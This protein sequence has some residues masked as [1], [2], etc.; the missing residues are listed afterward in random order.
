MQTKLRKYTIVVRHYIKNLKEIK[1]FEIYLVNKKREQRDKASKNIN[2][3]K[4]LNIKRKKRR[5]KL[6]IDRK[7]YATLAS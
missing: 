3:N 4:K 5:E 6:K 1:I 7:L 2:Y